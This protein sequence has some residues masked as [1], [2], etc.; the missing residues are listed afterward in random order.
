MSTVDP[1][2]GV[3]VVEPQLSIIEVD[4]KQD[5]ERD[6]LPPAVNGHWL[7]VNYYPLSNCNRPH[8]LELLLVIQ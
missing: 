1:V 3:L 6:P 2:V 8:P 4:P 5:L 7:D